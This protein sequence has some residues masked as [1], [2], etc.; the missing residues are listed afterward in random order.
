M[1]GV[2]SFIALMQELQGQTCESV[3]PFTNNSLANQTAYV[4]VPQDRH[5][6]PGCQQHV[7]ILS[8]I[9]TISGCVQTAMLLSFPHDM[10]Q[11]VENG[12]Q[13]FPLR[14]G[15]CL[16]TRLFNPTCPVDRLPSD[17]L[18]IL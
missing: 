9:L 4:L 2:C 16:Q 6:C 12:P 7:Q 13:P 5:G 18:T 11:S 10:G 15:Q 8:G 3:M 14:L 17:L 1:L